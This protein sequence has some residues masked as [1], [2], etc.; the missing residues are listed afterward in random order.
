M[1]NTTHTTLH[2]V[3]NQTTFVSAKEFFHTEGKAL[4]AEGSLTIT[5]RRKLRHEHCEPKENV[6]PPPIDDQASKDGSDAICWDHI[7]TSA[8]ESSSPELQIQWDPLMGEDDAFGDGL[9]P[10]LV[11]FLICPV[12]SQPCSDFCRPMVK[13]LP[14]L[15]TTTGN[16][17]NYGTVDTMWPPT[18]GFGTRTGTIRKTNST[19]MIVCA[20]RTTGLCKKLVW[21]H[22]TLYTTFTFSCCNRSSVSTSS[23]RRRRS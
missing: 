17:A 18:G 5:K 13:T 11:R 14:M 3:D 8:A 23:K 16:K 22:Y 1:Q 20:M 7:E 10:L 15:S 9:D 12:S 6:T 21:L 4:A 2:M 19:Q